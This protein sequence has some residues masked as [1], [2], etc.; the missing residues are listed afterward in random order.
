MYAKHWHVIHFIKKII[1]DSAVNNLNRF[2][3]CRFLFLFWELNVFWFFD[4][5]F[6]WTF[7]IIV[8]YADWFVVYQRYRGAAFTQ[9][10]LLLFFLLFYHYWFLMFQK[11][12]FLNKYFIFQDFFFF[13][14]G[15]KWRVLQPPIF[16][17]LVFQWKRSYSLKEN[18]LGTNS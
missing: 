1:V 4:Y 13:F 17:T 14:F 7:V 5:G 2:R 10:L 3:L 11:D 8:I 6:G 15:K 18:F 9:V 12:F 16:L